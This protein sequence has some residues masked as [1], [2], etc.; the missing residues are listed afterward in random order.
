MTS[1]VGEDR[2]HE[3]LHRA[4]VEICHRPDGMIQELAELETH[5]RLKKR[6]VQTIVGRYDIPLLPAVNI[7]R[8]L[9]GKGVAL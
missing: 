5:G 7:I 1:F 2:I 3:L 6:A 8:T 4:G 9:T